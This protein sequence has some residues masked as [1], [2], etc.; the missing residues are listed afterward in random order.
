M[1][2]SLMPLATLRRAGCSRHADAISPLPP[3]IIDGHA[4]VFRHA[5][6]S[7][8]PLSYASH[9]LIMLPRFFAAAAAMITLCR[10]RFRRVAIF[11]V[12]LL[13]LPHDDAAAYDYC[14]RRACTPPP[15]D[16]I[17][18][19]F[20]ATP[21]RC[22]SPALM[23]LMMLSMPPPSPFRFTPPLS[24]AAA[25]CFRHKMSRHARESRHTVYK[26]SGYNNNASTLP[27]SPCQM[28]LMLITI[29][30]PMPPAALLKAFTPAY[31][32]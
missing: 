27:F 6:A 3:D 8:A 22:F 17:I 32:D 19:R 20:R 16:A 2:F 21:L 26:I 18:F 13:M 30:P 11:D 24:F 31:D 7:P 14:F 15:L 25:R 1:P 23:M 9:L 4:S 28:L 29:R 10:C 5:D 12:I